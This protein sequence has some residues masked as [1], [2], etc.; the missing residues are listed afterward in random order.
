MKARMKGTS[1]CWVRK[2]ALS[3]AT[4]TNKQVRVGSMKPVQALPQSPTADPSSRCYLEF[5]CPR[6]RQPREG[7]TG[8]KEQEPSASWFLAAQSGQ[9]GR[10]HLCTALPPPKLTTPFDHD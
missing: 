3:E 6:P 2:H 5:L 9:T 8:D 4:G 1:R 10:A 7:N